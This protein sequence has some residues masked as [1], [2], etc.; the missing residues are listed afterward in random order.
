MVDIRIG[1]QPAHAGASLIN[2]GE[3]TTVTAYDNYPVGW[4]G[5]DPLSNPSN[6][7]TYV[8]DVIKFDLPVGHPLATWLNGTIWTL[9]TPSSFPSGIHNGCSTQ[10]IQHYTQCLD[11]G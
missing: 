10:K 6:N 11:M 7:F 4:F 5:V 1:N 9:T 3:G 2:P 8:G